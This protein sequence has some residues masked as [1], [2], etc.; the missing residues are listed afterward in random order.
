MQHT[1]IHPRFPQLKQMKQTGNE[2][3]GEQDY[4]DHKEP[5]VENE[6]GE[7]RMRQKLKPD[8]DPEAIRSD[9]I[10]TVCYS[11]SSGQSIRTVAKT[12]ELSPMKVRKILITAGAYSTELSTEIGELFKDGKNVGEIAEMLNMTPAN[13]N[14]YLPYERII[15]NMEEKS[16]NADRQQRYRDRL[17]AT[18]S[19]SSD[20]SSDVE[21]DAGG[22]GGKD[23]MDGKTG[24]DKSMDERMRKQERIRTKTLIIVIGRKLRKLIPSDVLDDTSDPLARDQSY[25]WGS[26]VG[27]VFTLHEAPDP[28]KMI[29]CVEV[30]SSG[31]GKGKKQG[32]VLMS[33][34]CGFCCIAPLPEVPI[35]AS[36]SSE[37]FDKMSWEDRRKAEEERRAAEAEN[38][39]KL[40]SFRAQLET[41]MLDSIR[42]GF[43]DFCLPSDRVM[44]YTDT[45]RRV[46][47]VK[48]RPSFPQ[49]RLEELIEREL[50]WKD[51]T[52]PL[53]HFNIRGNWTS[54]KF[55][56]STGYR[57]VDMAVISMLGLDSKE[58]D[59][60]FQRFTAPMREKMN[61][62]E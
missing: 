23:G 32:I 53:E 47:L 60:W 31:R 11:Y 5:K 29:W 59:E 45:V 30:T 21:N 12:L 46:E 2:S 26:N 28:D 10:D 54:R 52:D 9:L 24:M 62:G 16:V 38:R 40:K 37:E 19:D 27:G 42:R 49:T 61:T 55:G 22:N 50:Q 20:F 15:Y 48:G 7:N 3:S 18:M 41:V 25:T 4:E 39:E 56:N 44:D 13:V 34:N 14:S 58:Q 1:S 43:L 57:A 6:K 8:Y 51:G 33:A 35:L 17:L 36:F